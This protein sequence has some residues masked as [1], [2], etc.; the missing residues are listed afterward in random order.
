ML[1]CARSIA[2][3]YGGVDVADAD[4]GAPLAEGG[5]RSQLGQ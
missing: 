5:L 3:V 4:M 2:R 1:C